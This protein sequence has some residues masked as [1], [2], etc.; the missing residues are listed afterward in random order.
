DW[1]K[2]DRTDVELFSH[3][4][5]GDPA[6][7][8][9]DRGLGDRFDF[10]GKKL[11]EFLRSIG[12]SAFLRGH[13]YKT[14]GTSF[15]GNRCLTIHTSRPYRE[16]GNGGILMASAPLEKRIRSVKDIVVEQLV[17]DQWTDYE[18]AELD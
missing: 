6:D 7:H 3:V 18:V 1:K 2:R 9:I 8:A 12:A 5:W 15:Y 14:V 10:N 4:T 11:A 16:C 13:G 17:D